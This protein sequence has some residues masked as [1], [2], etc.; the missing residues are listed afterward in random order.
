MLRSSFLAIALL[1]SSIAACSG[2]EQDI[3]EDLCAPESQLSVASLELGMPI[4]SFVPLA[5]DAPMEMEYGLQG[6]MMFFF[7]MRAGGQ[8]EPVCMSVRVE[9][10]AEDGTI[11]AETEVPVRFSEN[12]DGTMIVSE[13]TPV[14]L[15]EFGAY[16]GKL[17]TLRA[18]IGGATDS[19]RVLLREP[20]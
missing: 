6:G 13:N 2:G 3:E 20:T 8:D 11:F 7:R 18:S 19:R 17:A 10:I 14:V 15:F 9:L 1:T 16:D 5:A 12:E 4:G